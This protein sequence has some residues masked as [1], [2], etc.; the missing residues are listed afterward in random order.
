MKSGRF[1]DQKS[2]YDLIIED[3]TPNYHIY[4]QLF[5]KYPSTEAY[6]HFMNVNLDL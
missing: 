6:S 1:T 4:T 2:E 3:I 5:V